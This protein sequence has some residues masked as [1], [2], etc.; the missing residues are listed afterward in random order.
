MRLPAPGQLPQ[1]ERFA[2]PSAGYPRAARG[3]AAGLDFR[4]LIQLLV[5]ISL[6]LAPLASK[7][8]R[9]F[10]A[11]AV[12]HDVDRTGRLLQGRRDTQVGAAAGKCVWSG[13]ARSRSSRSMIKPSMPSVW[14]QG[15]TKRQ[16]QHQP[17]FD[18]D[19][20]IAPRPPPP[21]CRRRRPCGDRLGRHPDR[22]TAAPPQRCVVLRPVLNF[23]P[24]FRDWLFLGS[25]VMDV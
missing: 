9:T 8:D 14:R 15:S 10:Q 2:H 25:G 11:G 24:G 7:A 20:R 17:C 22:Q 3:C 16:P 18:G 5:G 1:P 19:I 6:A 13:T 4:H 21:S 12:D 23:V